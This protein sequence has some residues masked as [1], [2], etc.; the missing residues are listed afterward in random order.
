MVFE[1]GKA[2]YSNDPNLKAPLDISQIS[3]GMKTFVILQTLLLNGSVK[4]GS[5]I[6]FDEPEVHLHPNW[7]LLFAEILVM[8]QKEFKLTILLTTHSPYFIRAIQVYSAKYSLTDK[9]VYYLA[10]SDRGFSAIERRK[11]ENRLN[12]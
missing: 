2:R 10:E 6:I 5:I 8:L 7:Q 1:N 9:C 11:R 12:L 4:E 3:A